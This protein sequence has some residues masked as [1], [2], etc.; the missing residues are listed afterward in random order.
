MAAGTADP[1]GGAAPLSVAVWRGDSTGTYQTFTVPAQPFQ[2]VLDLVTYIQR[3]L[4]PTLT[5]R[6]ACRVGMCGSCAMT[7]NGVPR[8]TCRTHVRKVARDGR[9][10]IGPLGNM[11]VVKDLAVDMT[12]FF[13]AWQ[14]A[15]GRFIPADPGRATMAAIPPD[16]PRRAAADAGIECINCGV[17]HAACD[18]VRW[19]PGYPGP[20]ALNRVWTLVNDDKDGGRDIHLAAVAEEA[21]CHAC[22][23]HQSC[24]QHC[25]KHLNP[26][27][28]IAGLKRETV[29]AALQGRI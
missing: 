24:V 5:Y 10:T 17:C 28:A 13:E 11:P 19:T 22:H 20:A 15:S 9:V 8:W 23:S 21:G 12:A 27:G 1:A 3:R 26:T 4:D 6:F 14:H 16:D 7:V 29:R 18:V 25:P 2:T